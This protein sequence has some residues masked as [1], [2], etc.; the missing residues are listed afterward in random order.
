MMWRLTFL[1]FE[2]TDFIVDQTK[3]KSYEEKS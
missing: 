2:I 3:S 1:Y